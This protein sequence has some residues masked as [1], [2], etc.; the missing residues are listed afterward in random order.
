VY[1]RDKLGHD[2]KFQPNFLSSL[3]AMCFHPAI[4]C[5][6]KPAAI[7]PATRVAASVT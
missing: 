5:L 7:S 2:G 4:G 1:G 3:T 6:S